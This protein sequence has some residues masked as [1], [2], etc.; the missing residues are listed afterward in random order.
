MKSL[1]MKSLLSNIKFFFQQTF[2]VAVK[3]FKSLFFSPLFFIWISVTFIFLSFNFPRDLFRFTDSYIAPSF[4][5]QPGGK[6]IHFDVFMAHI[7]YLNLIFIFSVPVLSMKLFAEE[8]KNHT[9]DLLMT[10]PLSPMQMVLGKYLSLFAL[11]FVFLL[12]SMIYPLS[13]FFWADI[14]MGLLLS[15]YLGLL[16]LVSVYA[17]TGLF[18]SSLTS[19]LFLSVF[20]GVI[21]NIGL[22][23]ISQG[24]VFPSPLLTDI[25]DY[26][27]LPQHL[28]YFIKGSLVVSSF[29]FF[30]SLIVF[31]LFLALKVIEVSRWRF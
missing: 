1:F 2:L 25:M 29:V 30:F 28:G 3:D 15:S 24:Q 13:L 20:I 26:L 12:F 9:F 17:S 6:N 10:A 19:S 14:P 27:S 11:L 16:L 4:G 5:Q 7:S 31:F 18:G 22:F 21:L 23:F 8:K